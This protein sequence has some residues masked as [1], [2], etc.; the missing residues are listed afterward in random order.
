MNASDG[1]DRRPLAGACSDGSGNGL[2]V[3][4]PAYS[5][6]GKQIAYVKSRSDFANNFHSRQ[7]MRMNASTGA[8]K[9]L[10]Y[11]VTSQE[12]YPILSVPDWGVKVQR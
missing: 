11:N 10:I 6:D 8:N 7:L 3:T 4:R 5:P 9:Q 1:S 12:L 2:S